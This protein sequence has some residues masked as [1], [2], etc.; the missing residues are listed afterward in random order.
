MNVVITTIINPVTTIEAAT[1]FDN[2]SPFKNGLSSAARLNDFGA[3]DIKNT[4][5]IIDIH[6]AGDFNTFKCEVLNKAI[7]L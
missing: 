4:I 7:I 2:N 6:N 3:K 1:C 5:N